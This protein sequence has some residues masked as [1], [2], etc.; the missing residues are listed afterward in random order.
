MN[1]KLKTQT[2]PANESWTFD[3]THSNIGFNVRHLVITKVHGRFTQWNGALTLG[4]AD[5]ADSKVDFTIDAGSIDT[6]EPQRDAHL[7]S[8]DFFD[9]EKFPTIE[10]RS[11]RVEP[12]GEERYR[13]RKS[14]V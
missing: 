2:I 11:R 14:V 9:V 1:A 10:F 6:H 3:P 5:Y 13:D 8:A 4:G 7:R 12:A